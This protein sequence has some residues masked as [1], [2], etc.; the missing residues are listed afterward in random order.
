MAVVAIAITG[1]GGF[2]GQAVVKR[3]PD[4]IPLRIDLFDVGTLAFRLSAADTKTLIHLGS[5]SPGGIG[6]M[7][8]DPMLVGEILQ[9]DLNVVEAALRAGVERIVTVGSLCS[10]DPLDSVNG[11]YGVAKKMLEALL[12]A[13]HRQ[14]GMSYSFLEL[15]NLYGPGDQSEHLIPMAIRKIKAAKVSGEP[16]VFWGT[17]EE[18][19]AFMHVDDA[20]WAIQ[21]MVPGQDCRSYRPGPWTVRKVSEVIRL[22]C[23]LLDYEYF[24]VKYDATQ[25]ATARQLPTSHTIVGMPQ[26]DWV[27]SL[28]G[29]VAAWRD[30]D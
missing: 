21:Y 28:R 7:F 26:Q 19:R 17:G 11:P 12:V 3:L 20:A 24:R 9:V 29:V 5:P 22:L 15:T 23:M 30:R 2:L 18:E 27:E 6:K 4:A 13:A 16:P 8:N 10:Y 1:A 25:P 14:S